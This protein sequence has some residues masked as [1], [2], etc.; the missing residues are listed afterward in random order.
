LFAFAS[1]GFAVFRPP[2]PIKPAAPVDNEYIVV[3]DELML[4]PAKKAPV[5]HQGQAH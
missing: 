4:R 3:G 5:H 2:F 1:Q